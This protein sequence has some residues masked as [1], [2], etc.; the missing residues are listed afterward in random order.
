MLFKEFHIMPS[1]KS[2][3][4]Y[5]VSD[6]ELGLRLD[7]FLSKNIENL[8]RSRIKALI[9]E[10]NVIKINEK[11]KVVIEDPSKKVKTGESYLVNIPKPVD[12]KPKPQKI[13]LEILYEDDDL[14]VINKPVGLVVHPAP[15]NYENTLVNALIA[16]CGQS[17][18]GISGEKKPG[19]VHRLDKD[20]S[21]VMVAAKNDKTHEGLSKQFA[22]HGRD[23]KLIRSYKALVW[24]VPNIQSGRVET[25]IGRSN[26]NRKKMAAYKEEKKGR[27]LAITFWKRIQFNKE[28]DIS[29]IE[30]NLETGRTHQ[31]R[32]HLT[33]LGLPVIGDQVYGTGFKSKINKYDDKIKQ[34]LISNSHRQALHAYKL[35]FE[36]P[37]TKESLLFKTD[38]PQDMQEILN[39]L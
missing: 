18:S 9:N 6:D 23:D 27:K 34:I 14:I 36:H 39:I 24:G 30:C 38:L 22:S 26:N 11:E 31:I 20:T 17:L 16:H 19:I 5:K 8:S 35:G 2:I 13:P 4:T 3:L 15:G 33:H 25:F 37:L 12:P 7:Q 29:V 32:V 10:N 28:L 1:D 21:G